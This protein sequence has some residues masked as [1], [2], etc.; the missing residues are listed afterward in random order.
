[1]AELTRRATTLIKEMIAADG[2]LPPYNVSSAS[3]LCWVQKQQHVAAVINPLAAHCVCRRKWC[4][5]LSSRQLAM[6]E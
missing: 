2:K 1:M 5:K 4:G 6:G 3:R